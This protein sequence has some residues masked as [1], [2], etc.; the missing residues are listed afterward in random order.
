MRIE[1]QFRRGS[2]S[3]RANEQDGQ[4]R[5]EGYF[6]VFDDVY[7]LFPGATES[8]DPHAFDEALDDDV[9]AL[10]NHEHHLVLGRTSNGTLK[11]R[12][13]ARGLWGSILINPEDVDAMNLYARVKRGDVSQ[14]S[15]GF[16][17]LDQ[18][19]D[20]DPVSGSAHWTI[21]KVKL[22][23]VSCVTFPAYN[24]TAIEARAGEHQKFKERHTTAW[25]EK[26]KARLTE[27]R[28][29]K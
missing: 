13:D 14:C 10:N 28:S 22:Y 1:R 24:D 25:R 7:E 21:Q 20:I 29:G 2:T 3:F 5:I 23:E 18:R 11:L 4:R 12:V 15:F 16:D 19:Q 6:A 9:R 17:I 26:W 27:W 8:I